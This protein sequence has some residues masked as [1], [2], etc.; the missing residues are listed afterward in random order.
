ML[1]N[2]RTWLNEGISLGLKILEI[3]FVEDECMNA[4]EAIK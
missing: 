2:L 1:P 3:K 4:E